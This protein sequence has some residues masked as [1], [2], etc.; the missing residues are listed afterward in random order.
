MANYMKQVAEML[1]VELGEEFKVVNKGTES[2]YVYR[3][4][5]SGCESLYEGTWDVAKMVLC[6]I[7]HG[8][9]EV[10]KLPY[11]P[12]YNEEFYTYF[13]DEFEVDSD[14]WSGTA[15]NYAK[16]KSGMVFRKAKDA[17]DAVCRV[18]QEVTGKEWEW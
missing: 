8:D 12:K 5:E 15:D 1:G 18:Y 14:I 6:S 7:L 4:T 16:L 13:G 9:A 2:Q 3:L 11:K 10:R 17:E